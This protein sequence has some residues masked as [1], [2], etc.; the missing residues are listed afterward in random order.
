[1][2]VQPTGTDAAIERLPET[3]GTSFIDSPD[4]DLRQRGKPCL[5]LLP[6]QRRPGEDLLRRR[7]KPEHL[8][9][10]GR[11]IATDIV[12]RH[13]HAIGGAAQRLEFPLPRAQVRFVV[14]RQSSS[15]KLTPIAHA[16]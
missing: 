4:T 16:R 2:I 3:C 14:S 8:V 1:M 6:R 10:V 9:A 13:P 15:H 12:D 5:A 11:D 7:G